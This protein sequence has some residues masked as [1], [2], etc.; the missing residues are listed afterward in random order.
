MTLRIVDPELFGVT[1]SS[2]TLSFRVEDA[3]GPV[4]A[5]AVVVV[6][7]E[8]HAVAGIAGTRMLRVE[9]LPA[10]TDL[11]VAI[12]VAG[13]AAPE[14]GPYFEGRVTTLTATEASQVA[15]FATLNDVHVGEPLFGGALD[16][17]G[18]ATDDGTPAVRAT[19]SDVP[20]WQFMN[21]DAVTDINRHDVDCTI[22]K[23][24]IADRGLAWQ[25]DAAA[26]TFAGFSKPWHAFLGNHDHYGLNVGEEVDGYALLGQPAAPRA[27]ELGGWKV[28][29]LDTTEPGEHHGI[30][31]DERLAWLAERLEDTRESA[32]P[33]LLMT[34]H[35]PV[36]PGRDKGMVN[37]I[38]L[39]PAH[40]VR[41][42]DLLEQHPQVR[43]ML[44]G[45]THRN[46]TR[47]YSQCPHVPFIEINCTKD[48]PGGWAHYRLFEDGHF[49][50]EVRRTPSE[51]ALAHSTLC[52]SFFDGGYR[53]FSLGSLSERSFISRAN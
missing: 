14:P 48:Y 23:G 11:A 45:H 42:F 6:A 49:R 39:N 46:R 12:E 38:G 27:L 17:D 10:G 26:S 29:L 51:R 43:A 9:D 13:A 22:I 44:I 41:I 28:L 52:S 47:I 5:E 1:E 20:Y 53:R 24:D 16:P 50:Q 34:H 3:Q 8:R 25:F 21:E 19:D 30:F 37:R 15:S 32:T 36:P 2:L 35:Q 40:S 31:P 18:P 33:T 7:G 4:D